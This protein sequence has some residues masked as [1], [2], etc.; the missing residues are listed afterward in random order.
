[1][2]IWLISAWVDIRT[3]PST[4]IF[5]MV[6]VCANAGPRNPVTTTNAAATHEG[7][8][9]IARIPR[10]SCAGPGWGTAGAEL[11]GWC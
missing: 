4:T 11:T 9:A 2:E 8:K 3:F 1:M 7:R 5:S 6:S 10:A